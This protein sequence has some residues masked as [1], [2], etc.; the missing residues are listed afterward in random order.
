MAFIINADN[1]ICYVTGR[2][3]GS[4]CII[5]GKIPYFYEEMLV[6]AFRLCQLGSEEC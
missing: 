4:L 6:L 3:V 1:D 2:D 5:S